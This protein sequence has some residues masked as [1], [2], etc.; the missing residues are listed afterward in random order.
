MNNTD[1]QLEKVSNFTVGAVLMAIGLL[2]T[3]IGAMIVPV[4]GLLFSVP[5]LVIAGIFLASPRSRAC[6]IVADKARGI[7]N[8]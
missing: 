7:V 6:S 5:V 4:I 8:K 2:F 3:L 1:C